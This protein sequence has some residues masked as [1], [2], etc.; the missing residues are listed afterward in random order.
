MEQLN[1]LDVFFLAIVG[2]SALVGIARGFT[3][4]LLS[5]VGWLVAGVS[6]YFLT[7]IVNPIVKNYITSDILSNFI[8]GTLVLL[9]FCIFWVLAVDKISLSIRLSKLGALDR[10]FGLAFG[11]LRGAVIIVLLVMMVSAL[12]PEDS[13]KGTFANSKIFV[14]SEEFVGPLKSILPQETLNKM[15]EKMEKFG[16]GGKNTEEADKKA[17]VSAS[18]DSKDKKSEKINN[19][20]R[21]HLNSKAEE[22]DNTQKS[23]SDGRINPKDA[24]KAIKTMKTFMDM[25]QPKAGAEGQEVDLENLPTKEDTMEAIKTMKTFMD[26]AQPKVEGDGS[27]SQELPAQIEEMSKDI[28]KLMNA[29][30]KQTISTGDE[31]FGL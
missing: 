27:N 10:I 2:I 6:V 8:S 12:I 28:E 25:A 18:K 22:K 21:K 1:S 9:S 7:P 11:I 16:F 30:E 14:A 15:Q 3:K 17:D 29:I 23:E 4:E 19:K 13:K 24:V 20:N 5:V 31:D 26:L